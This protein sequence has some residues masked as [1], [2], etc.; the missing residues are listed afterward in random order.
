MRRLSG[1]LYVFNVHAATE[2]LAFRVRYM[3]TFAATLVA[4]HLWLRIY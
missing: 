1:N 3:F 4:A 2:P